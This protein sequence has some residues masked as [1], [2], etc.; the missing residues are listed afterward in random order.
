LPTETI[1][2]SEQAR[3]GI[4]SS[5]RFAAMF[6]LGQVAPDTR[7][8]NIDVDATPR[9]DATDCDEEDRRKKNEK[10]R[11]EE[12]RK[13]K[14]ERRRKKAEAKSMTAA[15]S[16]LNGE[17]VDGPVDETPDGGPKRRKKTS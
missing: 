8:G 4:G 5:S 2:S 6:A 14:E 3:G 7:E 1:C 9:H 12:K 16:Q 15:G 13:A 17:V 10:K 11:A